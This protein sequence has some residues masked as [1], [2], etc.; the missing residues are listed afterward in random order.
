MRNERAFRRW[1]VKFQP[2]RRP[3]KSSGTPDKNPPA[4]PVRLDDPRDE[5]GSGHCA[6]RRAGIENPERH[7]AFF[8]WKPPR[9]RLAGAGKAAAFSHSEK[10]SKD[11]QPRHG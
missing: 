3:D 4:P 1:L 9:H 2:D 10:E 5:G 6:D 8:R 7:R 11:A